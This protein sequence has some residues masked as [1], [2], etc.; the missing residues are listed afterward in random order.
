M[1][2][3]EEQACNS[4]GGYG[5]RQEGGKVGQRGFWSAREA[6]ER[7]K[8]LGGEA[9][10]G[11]EVVKGPRIHCKDSSGKISEGGRFGKPL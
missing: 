7:Y 2:D 6:K 9:E 8:D 3:R 10:G 11:E 4:S 5:H 1:G